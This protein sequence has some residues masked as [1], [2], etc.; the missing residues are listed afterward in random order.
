M[1]GI[2]LASVDSA[3]G[4]RSQQR[5]RA[6]RSLWID[7][8]GNLSGSIGASTLPR[9]ASR[10]GRCTRGQPVVCSGMPAASTSSK[11]VRKFAS[12]KR[13]LNQ[14]VAALDLRY[15][16]NSGN[17]ARRS[18][19]IQPRA[20]VVP[21]FSEPRFCVE[22]R[23]GFE[24]ARWQAGRPQRRPTRMLRMAMRRIESAARAKVA[25]IALEESRRR[26]PRSPGT[27]ARGPA[28]HRAMRPLPA[29][30]IFSSAGE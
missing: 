14:L 26:N 25:T 3:A 9:Q 4:A 20:A 10:L 1:H 2:A 27:L 19:C 8:G 5:G 11:S 16:W 15:G 24:A 18:M 21:G 28:P 7:R 6:G 23:G 22:A 12:R 30:E 17:G 29:R 13:R